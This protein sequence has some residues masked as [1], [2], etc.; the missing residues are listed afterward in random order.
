MKN[1][2]HEMENNLQGINSK[3]DKVK[4][5]ISNWKY[6][7]AKNTWSE[8]QKEK[9]TP[10]QKKEDSLR[11]LWDNFKYTTI[12]I[13]WVPEGQERKQ[14]IENLFENMMTEN[15]PTQVKKIDVQ[16]QEMQSLK[17]NEPIPRGAHQ[18]TS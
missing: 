16:V 14:E 9:R 1:T 7:E 17:Q 6:M 12:L 8:Q 11:D 18:D 3:E 10:P 13:M 5:Q 2:L 4:N 15:V